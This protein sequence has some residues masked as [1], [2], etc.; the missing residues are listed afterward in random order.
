MSR[1]N[2]LNGLLLL[3]CIMT[4]AYASFQSHLNIVGA[5][6]ISS[7]FDVE[8]ENVTAAKIVGGASNSSLV[9]T[10]TSVTFKAL[11]TAPGDMITYNVMVKNNGSIDAKVSDI[12][13]S[14]SFN[15]DII[16]E[17]QGIN[18]GDILKA[19]D[20]VIYTV[21]VKYNNNA[22][23][24]PEKLDASLTVKNDYQQV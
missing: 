23:S 24:M 6:N 5:A 4:I 18:E 12:E 10:G 7:K 13:V 20:F 16:F 2:I 1:K 21:I 19:N 17:V 3:L 22:D 11:L 8:I 14:S 15:D 9:Y